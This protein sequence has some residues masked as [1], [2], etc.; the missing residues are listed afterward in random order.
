MSDKIT[1]HEGDC[2]LDDDPLDHEID[3]SKV[4][5]DVE[6]TR[7]MKER[8]LAGQV[9]IDSDLLEFFKTLGHR[10]KSEVLIKQSLRNWLIF[11]PLDSTSLKSS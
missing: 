3:F 10:S 9:R 1:I 6:H 4:K 8:A 2:N 7:R 5:I 11:S